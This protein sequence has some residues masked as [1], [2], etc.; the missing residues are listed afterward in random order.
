MRRWHLTCSLFVLLLGGLGAF[1]QSNQVVDRLLDEKAAAFGDAAYLILN[2]AGVVPESAT[3]ADAVAAVNAGGYF[4]G[5]HTE[6]QPMTLGEACFLIMKTQKMKGGVL[7]MLLPGPRYAARE[8][9]YLHLVQGNTHPGRT[10]TGE[11]V[12][13]MLEAAIERVGGQS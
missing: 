8:F 6:T 13:R 11:E 3:G 1:A 7:Y 5:T 12:M 4:R 9:V 2:A 10:V